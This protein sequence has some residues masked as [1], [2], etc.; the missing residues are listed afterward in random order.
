MRVA[1][2]FLN[3]FSLSAA[4]AAHVVRLR[5]TFPLTCAVDCL[6]YKKVPVAILVSLLSGRKRKKKKKPHTHTHLFQ[7]FTFVILR[8]SDK[9]INICES[10]QISSVTRK[11][12]TL[13][14]ERDHSA[15]CLSHQSLSQPAQISGVIGLP[16]DTP[17]AYTTRWRAHVCVHKQAAGAQEHTLWALKK[18]KTLSLVRNTFHL[19]FKNFFFKK[20]VDNWWRYQLCGR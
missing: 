15:H 11:I 18:N 14:S 19:L 7:D 8:V 4:A 10:E 3:H 16:G 9:L 5:D 1:I 6:V 12:W 17:A 20:R 2:K 13:I